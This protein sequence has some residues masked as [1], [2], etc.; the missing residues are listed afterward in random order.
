MRLRRTPKKPFAVR[1]IGARKWELIDVVGEKVVG[2][3]TTD[4]AAGE[5]ARKLIV[6]ER[7][8]RTR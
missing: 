2:V 5:M 3:F 6:A 8:G 4:T 7:A 1:Q